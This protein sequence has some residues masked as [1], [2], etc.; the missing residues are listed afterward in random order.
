MHTF[1]VKYSHSDTAAGCNARYYPRYSLFVD[2]PQSMLVP[3]PC[4]FDIKRPSH[5]KGPE[6]MSNGHV[7]VASKTE[8]IMG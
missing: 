4:F 7:C 3:N 8:G 6:C 5:F 2:S 1:R